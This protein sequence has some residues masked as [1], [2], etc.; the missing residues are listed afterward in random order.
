MDGACCQAEEEESPSFLTLGN[1][2]G[3]EVI[4]PTI[5]KRGPLE[6]KAVSVEWCSWDI[7]GLW[8]A[9]AADGAEVDLHL[10]CVDGARNVQSEEELSPCLVGS[11]VT[12]IKMG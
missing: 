12:N 1:G 7:D 3:S 2:E 4:H 9:G 6:L 11:L 8:A 5:L 10:D